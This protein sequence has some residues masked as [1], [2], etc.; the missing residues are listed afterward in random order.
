LLSRHSIRTRLLLAFVT[1]VG[2]TLA[3][4]AL[5]LYT[6][7]KARFLLERSRLAHAVLEEHLALRADTLA[8]F[9]QLV[10]ALIASNDGSISGGNAQ[11]ALRE[12]ISHLREAIVAELTFVA[13]TDERESEQEELRS[14]NQIEEEIRQITAAFRE[15]SGL[16]GAGRWAD[17]TPLL[18]YPR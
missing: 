4:T 11:Q 1:L 7:A 12:R 17:A 6:S 14:V 5:S 16:V 3:V 2:L 13:A 18:A 15:V 8:L 10:D 9:K